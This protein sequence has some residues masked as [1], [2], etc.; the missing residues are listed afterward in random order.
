MQQGVFSD[1]E[2]LGS[3]QLN[4]AASVTTAGVEQDISVTHSAGLIAPSGV[5]VTAS[6]LTYTFTIASTFAVVF[7]NGFIGYALGNTAGSTSNV[8]TVNL[9]SFVPT[10]G[11]QLVYIVATA[12]TVQQSPFVVAGPPSGHPDFNPTFAP[13]TAY[14]STANTLVIS[15]TTTA[16]D[17]AVYIE[18]GRVTLTAGQTS[19]TPTQFVT[20]YQVIAGSV[21]ANTGVTAA[22]YNNIGSLVVGADGRIS[23]I[24]EVAQTQSVFLESTTWTCPANIFWVKVRCWGAGGSGASTTNLEYP[25]G[26]GGGGG[27]GEGIYPVVPG[28]VYF[29]TVG[30]P[31]S[32]TGGSSSFANPAGD[33]FIISTGG[34]GGSV[35]TSSGAG[36]P[37]AGG[38]STGGSFS[39]P[40]VTG[41]SVAIGSILWLSI[42]GG[43]FGLSLQIAAGAPGSVTPGGSG[44]TPGGGS[45]GSTGPLGTAGSGCVILEY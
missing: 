3:T 28:D 15:A 37:G 27:Y 26:S 29:V 4:N 20:T 17:N 31:T 23:S 11:S 19:V 8:Y 24:A 45:T 21:L 5:V 7:A 1:A 9:S 6:T 36:A 16:P 44:Q 41:T 25:G 14:A 35:G 30:A 43:A 18:L 42:A 39:S 10:S 12:A 33:N 34:S 22:N 13:Y 40:G 2:F 32:G 38:S